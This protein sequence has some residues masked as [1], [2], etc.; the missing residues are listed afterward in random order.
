MGH[1][2]LLWK[3]LILILYETGCR[4]S[5]VPGKATELWKE[6]GVE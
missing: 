4:Q 5:E 3:P 6:K 1:S 2:Q